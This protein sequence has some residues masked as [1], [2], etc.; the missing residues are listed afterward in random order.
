MTTPTF[1]TVQVGDE[2][3]VVP[4]LFAPNSVLQM[5]DL[6]TQPPLLAQRV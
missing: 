5:G 2:L 1:D 6:Q 3:R 4:G